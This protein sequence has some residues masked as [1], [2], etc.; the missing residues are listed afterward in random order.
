MAKNQAAAQA[1]QTDEEIDMPSLD[2]IGAVSAD[3]KTERVQVLGEKF[4]IYGIFHKDKNPNGIKV[5]QTVG[6][7][8]LGTEE[9]GEDE[10]GDPRIVQVFKNAQG[11]KFGL[12]NR[13]GMN[14]LNRVPVGTF[15][16]VTYAAYDE[17]AVRPKPKHVFE[18]D[19]AAGTELLPPPSRAPRA[20][21]SEA[22]A[23]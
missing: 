1:A 7:T 12:W 2:S 20:S 15:V 5:G 18:I 9:R 10:N 6:G 13:G 23:N 17:A 22:R 19:M 14:L 11:K 4:P 21:M 16:K 8:Y 3:A